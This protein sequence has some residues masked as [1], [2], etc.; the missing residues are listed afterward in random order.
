M[1]GFYLG[2]YVYKSTNLTL[3]LALKQNLKVD[4][5]NLLNVS[6]WCKTIV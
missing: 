6:K 2:F 4:N 3:F 1:M 5:T